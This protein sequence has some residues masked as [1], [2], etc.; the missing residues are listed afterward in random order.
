M[1]PEMVYVGIDV[2]KAR[3]DIAVRPGGDK[4]SEANDDAGIG[5]LVVPPGGVSP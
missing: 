4:W 1:K 5:R 2:S 3:L